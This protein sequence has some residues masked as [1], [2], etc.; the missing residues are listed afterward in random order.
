MSDRNGEFNL[1]RYDTDTKNITALT[2]FSDFPVI[3]LAGCGNRIIFE[4]AGR[5]HLMDT[6]SGTHSPID[7]T[8]RTDKPATRPRYCSDAK[9]IR[10]TWLSPNGKRLAVDFRGEIVTV[11]AKKGDP[12]NISQS[13]GSHERFPCW[14]PDGQYLACFSDAGGE[15]NLCLYPAGGGK[16]R[17]YPLDGSGFYAF[18]RWSPDAKKIC[19]V[20]NGRGLY[21][22]DIATG[23]V[24]KV[25]QQPRYFPGTY[26]DLQANWSP[27]SKYIAYVLRSEADFNQAYIY[28]LA[29]GKN[30][31]ITDGLS[32]VA[33]PT[34]DNNGKYLY[35][36]AS[37]NAGPRNHWFAMSNEENQLTYSLYLMVLPADAPSPLAKESDEEQGAKK[38]DA[39][40]GKQTK[41]TDTITDIDLKGLAQRIVP[42][43]LPE[44]LYGYLSVAG[45]GNIYYLE[46]PPHAQGGAGK[47][48]HYNLDAKEDKVVCENVPYY[49]IAHD[50]A[51]IHYVM[52]NRHHITTLQA[53]KPGNGVLDMAAIR[54]KVEP[55]KEWRQIFNEVWRIQRDYF[56]DPGMHGLNWQ[57][58]Y[59]KYQ[60]FL[61]HVACRQDLNR[62][63]QW[64]ISEMVVGHHWVGGGDTRQDT[65]SVPV[66]LL[67]ADYTIDQGRYRFKRIYGGLNW[68]PDLRSPLVQPGIN[69]EEG[70]YLLAVNGAEVTADDNLFAFFTQTA[71]RL[72]S[73]TV[74][75]TAAGEDKRT[76][77]VEPVAFEAFLRNRFWVEDNLR[78]VTEATNGRVAYVYV[79]NTAH[80][81]YT[82]FKRYF[83]P[84]CD[85]E[86]I[87]L[88]ERFNGGGSFADYYLNT[89]NQ[90]YLCSWT[91]RYGEP[92][93]SPSA[94]IQ[95]PKV[96]LINE[97]AGSGGDLLPFAFR[98]LGIGPL[99]GKRT[100][101]GLVGVLGFPILIDGGFTS[102][103]NLAVWTPEDGYF[104]ENEGI[105]PDPGMEVEQDPAAV[106]RGEDPQLEKAI[107]VIMQQLPKEP[108][109]P[110]TPPPFPKRAQ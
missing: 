31:A 80:M 19:F 75:K 41:E 86:A 35:L 30:V 54:V 97:Y 1:F 102:A 79:P 77:Q 39:E 26:E 11:P 33:Q 84:Q 99:I 100:W 16:E 106:V 3:H 23:A 4:Q 74:A 58:V 32:D 69:V 14:S 65:A 93:K 67:G 46:F 8:V 66:G 5:L 61:D 109:A 48:H 50:N 56:Y 76:V 89:L 22:L 85:R 105:A 6:T 60:P 103:P 24:T 108:P 43:P 110:R 95:G 12:R 72:V 73:I 53:L 70:D 82:Y 20:D 107:E 94:S 28:S 49:Q 27:D 36:L 91:T 40:E 59:D 18:P 92:Y 64:M 104:I 88:D 29:S 68:N 37:T 7:I 78:K 62:L 96:L 34:F 13:P 21:I 83:Y 17:R 101:G 81:G 52:N 55:V 10:S 90:P 2:D 15:Y 9:Y 51:H 44:A 57:A 71:N 42:L 38:Q 63:M 45:P 98:K 25:G 87:I 47:L